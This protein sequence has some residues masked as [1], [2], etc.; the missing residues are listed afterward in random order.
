MLLNVF[1]LRNELKQ[2]G[3]KKNDR[4]FII[5]YQ[6]NDLILKQYNTITEKK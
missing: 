2:A 1:N 5:R 6:S 4:F 3:R